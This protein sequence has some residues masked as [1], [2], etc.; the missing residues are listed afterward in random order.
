MKGNDIMEYVKML[1]SFLG[2]TFVYLIGGFDNAIKLLLITIFLDIITGLLK[3]TKN[4][5]ID[6]RIGLKGIKRKIY[7]LCLVA[8]S[9][10]I[11]EIIGNSGIIRNLMV[12][13]IIGNEGISIIENAAEFGI[14]VP[15]I[16]RESLE[17]LKEEGEK[18]E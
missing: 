10:V 4:K 9:V 17:Q 2:T 6:S 5:S 3:A 18:N 12:Y 13:Y 15:K 16:L 14:Y 11:D 7:L 8:L 1:F